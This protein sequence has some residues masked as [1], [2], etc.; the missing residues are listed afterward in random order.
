MTRTC[1][2][3]LAAA[4]VS[5][6]AQ[7][8]PAISWESST[9]AIAGRPET[10]ETGRLSVPERH[11]R[12]GGKTITLGFIRLQTTSATPRAPIVYLDGGPGGSGVSTLDLPYMVTLYTKLR[13][14][15]DV[16]LLSQRGTGISQ[17]RLVCPSTGRLPEDALVSFEKLEAATFPAFRACAD[18]FRSNGVDVNAYNTQESADDLEA[19]RRA[20]GVGKLSLL[21]FSYGT[22]LGMTAMRR[23][24][25][26]FERVVLAG[27]EGP[28]ETLKLPSVY[29]AQIDRIAAIAKADPDAGARMPDL[30]GAL[31]ALLAKVR[32]KP[33]E[34]EIGT[35]DAGRRLFVGEAGIL[36]ILR[37]DIGDTNDTPWIPAFVHDTLAG[38]YDLLKTMVTRRLPQLEGGVALMGLAM[39]CASGASKERIARIR[40]EDAGSIF[41]RAVN[42]P[43]PEVC[44]TIGVP[45]L[46]DDFRTPVVSAT[47]TLLISG[48]L[49]SNTPPAQ[50]ETHRKGL[51][52]SVHIIVTNAGHESTLPVPEVQQAIVDFFSDRLVTSRTITIPVP[53]VRLPLR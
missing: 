38:N 39:D 18:R 46:G 44:D 5:A 50:A 11:G 9:R 24:P 37:R 43:H 7:E 28:D 17:P 4:L 2:L 52:R 48:T 15:A 3:L 34:I 47:P 33:I 30:T 31:K 32:E 29:N 40:A 53:R 25:G 45:Q 14:T 13:D 21:G 10:I 51:S 42:G 27:V 35:G 19:L 49:D 1:V 26:S 12:P 16:I 8:R 6:A 23:H 36:Y 41:G 20:L 22:H